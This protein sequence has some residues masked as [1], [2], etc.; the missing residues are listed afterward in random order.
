MSNDNQTTYF[1]ELNENEDIY[2]QLYEFS[3]IPIL[4]HD[5]DMNILDANQMASEEFGYS[6]EELLSMKV[7]ELH[8]ESELEH[9]AK[10]LEKMKHKNK[11]SVE[12]SFKRKDGSEF[13]AEATPCRFVIGGKSL[14]HVYIQNITQR[15]E[16]EIML[17]RAIERAE[18]SDRLKSEFLANMSHELRTPLNAI[19]GFA[20]FLKDKDKTEE[21]IDRYSDIIINSGQ[22]LLALLN[23]IIDISLIEAGKLKITKTHFELN[24]LLISLYNFFHSYLVSVKKFKVVLK[25]DIPENDRY[26][27]SDKT[28]IRQILTNLIGNAIK[29]TDHG[30]VE[31]GYK[32]IDNRINF[33][34]KDT[35]KGISDDNKEL[36]FERFRKAGDTKDKL[37][38]GTGLGLSIAKSCTDILGGDIWFE[39]KE[40]VGSTFFFVIKYEEGTKSE[41]ILTKENSVD[42]NFNNELVLIA[43]DDSYNFEFLDKILNENNLNTIRTVTGRE[44]IAKVI[45]NDNIRL[46]LMDIKMPDLSGITATEE[47][48]KLRPEIP[49]IAQTAFAYNSDKE[50]IL[51]AG[52]VE[53]LSKPIESNRLLRLIDKYIIRK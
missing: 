32:I 7:F 42:Y 41:N 48:K 50:D 35:G 15:K 20:Q 40:N 4:I 49:V 3:L 12:T 44:T 29:F 2:K 47:I 17:V 14:I 37:Y 1:H 46:I 34:V 38:G 26:I 30:E 16:D 28:R 23:D 53:Y 19:L 31:F 11:L 24:N 45:E 33:F 22:H 51:N 18:E 8:T 39:S 5:M 43:E 13:Y 6:K 36:I 10:V 27:I 52:C 9:S 25:L 21:E